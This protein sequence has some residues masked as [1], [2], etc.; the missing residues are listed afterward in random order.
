MCALPFQF[1]PAFRKPIRDRAGR[2]AKL[3]GYLADGKAVVIVEDDDVA[4]NGG[5]GSDFGADGGVELLIVVLGLIR[6]LRERVV[7]IYCAPFSRS[8]PEGFRDVRGDAPEPRL[9]AGFV[10][11]TGQRT[12]RCA[13]D[14]LRKLVSFVAG[15]RPL[16]G[17][18]VNP[19]RIERI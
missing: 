7:G 11:Q 6:K 4:V 19:V 9:K 17:I 5:K 15:K 16:D 13:E 2:N 10:F 8:A 14:F 18:A 3:F 12:D 1:F